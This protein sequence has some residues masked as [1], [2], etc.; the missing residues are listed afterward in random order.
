MK[1]F[2]DKKQLDE[3]TE[4][5]G[6]KWIRTYRYSLLFIALLSQFLFMPFL[7]DWSR[8][9]VP[10]LFFLVVITV[11][12]TLDLRRSLFV[13]LFSLG[14]FATLLHMLGSMLQVTAVDETYLVMFGLGLEAIF[15]AFVVWVLVFKVFSE[16]NVSSETIKGGISIY[17]LLGLLWAYLYTLVLLVQPDAISFSVSPPV[18]S[19]IVYFSFTTLT[20]LGYGDI[21]PTSWIARNLT[22]LEAT[23]G[24]IFLTVLIARLVG[25]HLVQRSQPVSAPEGDC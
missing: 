13:T 11:L 17:F 6:F 9:F 12:L 8:V 15:F 20:T 4:H 7:E 2:L 14:L 25:L 19:Q 3:L 24:Q 1:I 16:T 21:T 23:I 22:I 10:L 18:L 5:S